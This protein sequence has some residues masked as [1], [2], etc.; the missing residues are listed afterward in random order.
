MSPGTKKALPIPIKPIPP[1]PPEKRISKEKGTPSV[2]KS[3]SIGRDEKSFFMRKS[4]E[5]TVSKENMK[6]ASSPGN[7]SFLSN[8]NSNSK[9]E[10]SKGDDKGRDRNKDDKKG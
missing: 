7:T 8:S 2:I 3:P 5:R 6:M 9:D 10:S 4:I 1:I